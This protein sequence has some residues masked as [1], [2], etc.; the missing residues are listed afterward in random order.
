MIFYVKTG[1]KRAHYC[2]MQVFDEVLSPVSCTSEGRKK[3]V[4]HVSEGPPLSQVLCAGSHTHNAGAPDLSPFPS[5]FLMCSMLAQ[6][7]QRAW[8]PRPGEGQAEPPR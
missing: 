4:E 2:A 5:S 3:T 7:K 8:W 6:V 1:L